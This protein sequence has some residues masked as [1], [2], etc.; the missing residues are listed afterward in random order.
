MGEVAAL[1]QEAERL[2]N[3]IRDARKSANDL[4][5]IQATSNMEP[6]G[7]LQMR[8]RR[9]LRGHLAKIYAM[10]WGTDSRYLVSASQ[11]GKL[12]VWDAYTTNKV[13]AIPLRSSWVMIG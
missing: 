9:T 5:L 11:D 3:I 10:N 2:K 7:R 8:P 13:H 12:I 6:V 4:S 1:N